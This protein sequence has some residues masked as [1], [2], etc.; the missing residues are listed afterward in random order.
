MLALVSCL[1]VSFDAVAE[2]R[3][4]AVIMAASHPRYQ[5]IQTVF[6]KHSSSFCG[7]DCKMYVQTPNADTMSLRN[8]VRKAVALDADLIV[9]YGPS[10]TLAAKLESPP[11]PVLFADVYDPVSLGLVSEDSGVGHRMTGVRGDAPVQ[12]LFKYFVEST[13]ATS[14]AI[15]FD[16]ESMTG[17]QQELTLVETG[18]R[19]KIEV[20]SLPTK[21]KQDHAE[22][23][24]RMLDD[25]DGLFLANSDHAGS[26]LVKVIA[27]ATERKVPAITQRPGGAEAGAFMTLETSAQEQG[28]RLAGMANKLLSGTALSELPLEKPR[29]ISFVVNLAA[30][31]ACGVKVPFTVLSHATSVVK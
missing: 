22:A 5:E 2:E 12:A 21:G 8:S 26:Q 1:T 13:N 10:A 4:I 6:E 20:T 9:T 25:T 3:L 29:D 15:L 16:S 18:K 30:A 24:A 14:L 28:E 19:R 7:T 27:F 23:L 31:K 11:K 17:K